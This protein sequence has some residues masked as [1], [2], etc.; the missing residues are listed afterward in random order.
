MQEVVGL[1]PAAGSGTR[2]YPFSRAVP[3]EM[4]PI[5]GKAVI[6]HCIDNLREAGVFRAL[7][8][9]GHQK[10]ALM[11][12]LGDG[13]FFGMKLAYI[14]QL[15][16]GGLGHAIL[17]GREWINSTFTVMLG[18][19]FIEPKK[20]LGVLIEDHLK[21][22][23][24]ATVMLFE[25]DSPEGY[26]VAKLSRLADHHG[27]VES[28]VEKPSLNE[29]KPYL[30]DGKYYALCGAYVFEPEIFSYIER[31]KPGAKGEVQITDAMALALKEGKKVNA[32]ILRGKYLDIGKWKTVLK[33]EKELFSLINEDA[34][35]SDREA[36][37][38]KIKKH[39]EE[40]GR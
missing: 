18:D 23:P 28:L 36:M 11:D 21:K 24:I 15:R 39:E 10:G 6:E 4:Y 9:V 3:K 40:H 17:Q 13:S 1:I 22:K 19:S 16:R 7:L 34:C 33:I 14:Y 38:E 8:I 30:I 5:L 20:E 29:A 12:Y 27:T 37:M 35:I 26:G 32:V 25:V 2:L 31:T